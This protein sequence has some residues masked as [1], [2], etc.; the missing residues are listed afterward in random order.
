MSR[1]GQRRPTPRPLALPQDRVDRPLAAFARDCSDR[2]ATGR[3]A[4]AQLL[5][6]S[7]GVM[8][9]ATD[10]AAFRSGFGTTQGTTA[11]T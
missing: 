7:A 11:T 10:E 6:A 5:Y 1:G 3:H 2:D 8:R 9:I 4:R